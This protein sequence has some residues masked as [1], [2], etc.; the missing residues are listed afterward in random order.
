MTISKNSSPVANPGGYTNKSPFCIWSTLF[1]HGVY[2]LRECIYGECAH[3]QHARRTLTLTLTHMITAYSVSGNVVRVRILIYAIRQKPCR[4]RVY[5]R[6]HASQ[7][8]YFLSVS[9]VRKKSN[10]TT[11]FRQRVRE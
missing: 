1:Q 4:K 8:R 9:C 7:T 10:A 11:N 2:M 5:F 6:I 3:E